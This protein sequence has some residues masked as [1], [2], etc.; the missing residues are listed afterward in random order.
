MNFTSQKF[1]S[2]FICEYPTLEEDSSPMKNRPK[3]NP[4]IEVKMSVSDFYK[5]Q[6][7]EK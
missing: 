6:D 5:S 7:Q 2:P 1:L 4:I 3:P